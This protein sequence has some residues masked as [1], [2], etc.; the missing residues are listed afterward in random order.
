MGDVI[1]IA[2]VVIV[3]VLCGYVLY[4]HRDREPVNPTIARDA[5]ARPPGTGEFGDQMVVWPGG[6]GGGA[7]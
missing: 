5:K 3:A 2:V 7:G 6:S 1:F 4:R